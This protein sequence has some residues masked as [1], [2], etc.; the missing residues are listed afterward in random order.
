VFRHTRPFT[1]S[2]KNSTTEIL[3]NLAGQ[4]VSPLR[5][6]IFFKKNSPYYMYT[7]LLPVTTPSEA[8]ALLAWILRSLVRIPFKAWL[9]VLVFLCCDVLCR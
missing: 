8:K 4:F 5:K 7:K 2:H 1:I 6:I 9:F 3:Y